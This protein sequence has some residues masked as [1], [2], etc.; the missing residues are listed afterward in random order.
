MQILF[1]ICLVVLF[2]RPSLILA[3]T[4]QETLE[5]HFEIVETFD[6]LQDWRG[7]DG[8]Y[9]VNY[10]K[11]SMPV[12]TDG[13]P[14]MWD[15]YDDWSHGDPVGNWI[16]D[17]GSADVWRGVGKSLAVDLD[18]HDLDG[19]PRGAQRFGLYF[20]KADGYATSG[21]KDDGYNDIFIFYMVKIPHNHFPRDANGV[22]VYYGY[23][24]FNTL[25]SGFTSASKHA[26]YTDPRANVY[27]ASYILQLIGTGDSFD[28]EYIMKYGMRVFA[29]NDWNNH[30][31]LTT[32]AC[33]LAGNHGSSIKPY[34]NNDQWFGVEYHQTMETSP[35][36]HD[37]V[38]EVWIYHQNG[39]ATKVFS[40][41]DGV[42]SQQSHTYKYNKFFFGGNQDFKNENNLKLI[43]HVDDFI[44]N[45]SRIGPTYFQLLQGLP[46][47]GLDVNKVTP[48]PG[49]WVH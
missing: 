45:G 13:S 14:S 9:G 47:K 18:S 49:K 35:G 42:T 17:H 46:V 48:N 21:T 26:A 6:E 41:T 39:N 32:P 44:I 2:S 5:Q 34:I 27:G 40:K 29:W 31:H 4:W 20:K 3:E 15:F 33:N 24:K 36:A 8:V 23:Y 30:L 12:K 22:P 38:S 1:F 19:V 43:Y 7:A 28:H 16:A 11:G 37:A 10:N 25:G